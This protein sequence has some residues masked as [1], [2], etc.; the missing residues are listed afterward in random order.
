MNKAQ[1]TL[2][3]LL[4]LGTISQFA[5]AQGKHFSSGG[6]KLKDIWAELQRKPNDTILQKQYL[7]AFPHNYESFLGLFDYNRE[8]YNEGHEYI[9]MLPRLARCH[10]REVGELLVKLAGDAHYEADAPS[11][12]QHATATYG[13]QHTKMFVRSLKRLSPGKQAQLITFL[14]DVEN[15][16]A[17]PEY[18]RI[19]DHLKSLGENDL[20]HKFEVAREKRSHND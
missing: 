17:Y 9:E 18:Q 15:F 11:Y 12:L 16:S 20:A 14:A 7:A 3:I 5:P 1:V 19:V 8:L 13:S 4:L 10:E 6:G 2:S